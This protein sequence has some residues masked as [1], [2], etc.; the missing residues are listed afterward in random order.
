MNVGCWPRPTRRAR[1]R[2]GRRRFLR[3][4]LGTSRTTRFPR[5]RARSRPPGGSEAASVG[6]GPSPGSG[7]VCLGRR[8]GTALRTPKPRGGPRRQ[9][10]AV[11]IPHEAAASPRQAL[12]LSPQALADAVQ[13]ALGACA[14]R[15]LTA[16]AVA[17]LAV[18][19][20][21]HARALPK[22]STGRPGPS[23]SRLL[24]PAS[25]DDERVGALV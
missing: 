11:A 13:D 25:R 16:T 9:E 24:R 21:D 20:V 23:R 22:V 6:K 18:G 8:W 3:P 15:T 4:V 5:G 12:P 7:P 10:A 14:W 2:V 1:S 17:A 19:A